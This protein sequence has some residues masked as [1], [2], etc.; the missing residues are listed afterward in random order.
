VKRLVLAALV[1]AVA[2]AAVLAESP[3]VGS[4]D[5]SFG[6]YRPAIDS[7]P[8]LTRRPFHEIFGRSK[9]WL[10]RVG[11]S[12][13]VTH[14]FGSLEVGLQ[15]GYLTRSGYA[16]TLTGEASGDLT[17][18]QMIP[19]SATL[20]YRF[21]YLADRFNVPL[22]PYGRLA[23]E[24]YNW[25][26]TNGTGGTSGYGATNGWSAAAGLALLLDFFDP[27]LARELD[28]DTG[29]NHTYVFAEARKTK[30]NDFGSKK[31]WDLS[32]DGKLSYAFGMMFVF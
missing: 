12:Y 25:W 18:F 20:T 23:F 4:V 29:I 1:A 11:V 13:D 16:R 32:D 9:P 15:T 31:S 26:V 30:V 21:D 8:G 17:K 27:T 19:T 14:Y 3:R 22:A 10:F 6:Q 28:L 7:E 24:R 5:L 2:P